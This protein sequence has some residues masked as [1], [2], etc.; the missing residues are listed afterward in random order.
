MTPQELAALLHCNR[1]GD[2]ITSAQANAA[3]GAGLVV[4]FGASDDL[5]ELRGAIDDELGA[6]DG[7]TFRVCGDGLLKPW[8][9]DSGEEPLDEEDAERY[10][11]RK[12]AGFKEIEARWAPK[13]A[14]LSW[15]FKTDIPHATFDVMEDGEVFCRGIVFALKDVAQ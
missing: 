5:V 9:K 7:S 13:D 11:K 6:Y 4:V 12:A 1:I 15:D 8:P 2:E 10:F 3:K 14:D